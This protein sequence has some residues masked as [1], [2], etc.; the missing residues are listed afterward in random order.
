MITM[1]EAF[2]LCDIGE[3]PVYLQ[4]AGDK[5]N[6]AH[7]FWAKNVRELFDMKQVKVV[8]IRPSWAAYGPDYLGMKFIVR[9]V[10]DQELR[11]K[12]LRSR[13]GG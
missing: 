5:A 4:V 2:R 9:G 6:E 1:S 3:E 12:S 10:T 13:M 8:G 7:Y 11:E